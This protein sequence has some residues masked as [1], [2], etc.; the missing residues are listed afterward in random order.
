[1]TLQSHDIQT[2]TKALDTIGVSVTFTK[3]DNGYKGEPV[4][5]SNVSTSHALAYFRSSPKSIIRDFAETLSLHTHA[6]HGYISNSLVEGIIPAINE[7]DNNP[8]EIDRKRMTHVRISEYLNGRKIKTFVVPLTDI[9]P[10]GQF[11]DYHLID[12]WATVAMLDETDYGYEID[13]CQTD[14][15]VIPDTPINFYIKS[16]KASLIEGFVASD[17]GFTTDSDLEN[18]EDGCFD[19]YIDEKMREWR[20]EHLSCAW[21]FV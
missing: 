10:N 19:D 21:E 14:G 12:E 11:L 9:F 18:F 20:N 16:D 1:M 4:Q 17:F 13:D 8:S 5:T 6:P 7:L 3:T 2:I 15:I